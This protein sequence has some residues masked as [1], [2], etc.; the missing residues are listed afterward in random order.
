MELN[1]PNFVHCAEKE[2]GEIDFFVY[3]SGIDEEI[4]EEVAKAF[5]EAQYE[6]FDEYAKKYHD[7]WKITFPRDASQWKNASCTCPA[8]DSYYICK[9]IIGIAYQIGALEKPEENYDD[10]P[11]FVS[12]KGRPKRASGALSRD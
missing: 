3:R 5:E 10:E 4:T 6:S 1:I 12:K 2:N 11:L 8:F 7:V 9:H